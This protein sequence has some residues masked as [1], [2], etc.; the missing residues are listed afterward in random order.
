MSK[1]HGV[2]LDP[3]DR[4]RIGSGSEEFVHIAYEQ[5]MEDRAFVRKDFRET[6]LF[7]LVVLDKRYVESKNKKFKNHRISTYFLYL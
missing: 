1:A 3:V 2:T 5:D 4:T 6:W 7:D